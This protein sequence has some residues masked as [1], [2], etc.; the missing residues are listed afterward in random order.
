MLIWWFSSHFLNHKAW[1]SIN[2]TSSISIQVH[3]ILDGTLTSV[4]I[5][6]NDPVFLLHHSFVDY[7]LEM[8]IRR[9]HGKY[10]PLPEDT[11]AAKGHNYNDYV[12]PFLPLIK[13]HELLVDSR[14][15]GWTF[16][17]LNGLDLESKSCKQYDGNNDSQ[18]LYPRS[19]QNS[20]LVVLSM[21]DNDQVTAGDK[22]LE[23]K[24]DKEFK[25][26]RKNSDFSITS[27]NSLL[28][29]SVF[30][31]HPADQHH[32]PAHIICTFTSN[33]IIFQIPS[34]CDEVVF[35]SN[36]VFPKKLIPSSWYLC[37][38]LQTFSRKT[39]VQNS[40]KINPHILYVCDVLN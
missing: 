35:Q 27:K 17:S 21:D 11:S 9:H 22:Q 38:P 34:N 26:V 18:V 10:Q 37:S 15:Y 12:V 1:L 16:E 40:S 29:A 32:V 19:S 30:L 7:Y 13:C 6:S 5:A 31:E 36:L 3:N 25:I 23:S 14:K 28:S 8:W 24:L 20:S 33:K 4:P 2:V 39:R